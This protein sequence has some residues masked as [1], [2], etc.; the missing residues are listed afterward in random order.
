MK[1][2]DVG[3]ILGTRTLKLGEKQSV[4]VRLGSPQR[5]PETEGDYFCAY[6]IVV[7]GDGRVRYAIGIDALQAV[8]LT[9]KKIGADLYT[10][11]EA[12]SG[13]LSWE[14]QAVHG[15]LGFPVPD[16]IKDLLP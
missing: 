4:V 9:L 5:Y 3:Q 15:D 1:L 7:I 16:A 14:G 11:P 12:R 6:Q 10:T 13:A 8:L 2:D